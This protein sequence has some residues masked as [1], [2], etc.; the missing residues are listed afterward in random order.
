MSERFKPRDLIQAR[1]KEVALGVN[2]RTPP[3]KVN[4]DRVTYR[5]GKRVVLQPLLCREHNEPWLDCVRCS[6]PKAR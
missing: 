1:A 5:D 2:H 6:K 4:H 3:S